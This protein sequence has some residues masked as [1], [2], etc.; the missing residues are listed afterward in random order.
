MTTSAQEAACKAAYRKVP[1]L[2]GVK[3]S[4]RRVGE[5]LVFTFTKRVATSPGGPMLSQ[6]V[7][8]STSASGRV[9]KV[10]VGR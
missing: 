1:A 8:V 7:K 4:Q 2:R 9:E 3:P 10:V 5:S 6:R